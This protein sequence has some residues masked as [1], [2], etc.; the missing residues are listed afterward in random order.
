MGGSI[1][2]THC[3]SVPRITEQRKE[4]TSCWGLFS[5][6][7]IPVPSAWSTPQLKNLLF[8]M[9]TSSLSVTW[10]LLL[11]VPWRTSS[12]DLYLRFKTAPETDKLSRE[13]DS[14][15]RLALMEINKQN[16]EKKQNFYFFLESKVFHEVS[17]DCWKNKEKRKK[18]KKNPKPALT[19][20]FMA[21]VKTHKQNKTR[22]KLVSGT[23]PSKRWPG[24]SQKISSS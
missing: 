17:A 21:S 18:K 6:L 4:L 16:G 20:L 5:C 14:V 11:C 10:K 13:K 7:C 8:T 9:C 15:F 19:C 23:S 22:T 1:L 2:R 3:C 24:W 12:T